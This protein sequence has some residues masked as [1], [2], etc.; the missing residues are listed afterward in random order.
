MKSISF[1]DLK[2]KVCVITGGAGVLGTTMVRAMASVG[3]KVAIADINKEVAEKVASEIAEET[4]A[5]V[6][7]VEANVLDRESLER[8]KAEINA[9][10]GSIDVL[11]NGAGGNSP[12]A[13][14]R[15]EQMEEKDVDNPVDT[16]YGLQMEG[17]D[18]VYALNFKGTLLPTMV[19]TT[20]M[21]KNKKGVILNISSMNSFK[22]LTKIPAYSAA[23]ASVNNFTEWLAVHLAKVGIRVNAIAPGFFITNQNRFLV[24][25]EKSGGYS[26]RGQKIVNSTPMGKFGEPED[27]Q[28]ATL[29]LI[30][31]ISGFITGIVLPVDGGYSAFGGV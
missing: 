11:V 29:F 24:L 18:K 12:M 4:T 3:M 15:V 14:T 20:D 31:D 26:A 27:L 17:F 19:F 16:F 1:D 25:D 9:K 23:K 22:P 13:T 6:I 5:T 2:G 8:A 30:S 28:G 21:L 7:G 10:L